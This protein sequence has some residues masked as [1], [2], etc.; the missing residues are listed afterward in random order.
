MMRPDMRHGLRLAIE[1]AIVALAI[2]GG[3]VL[4]LAWAT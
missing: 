4:L 3:L 2:V 1:T